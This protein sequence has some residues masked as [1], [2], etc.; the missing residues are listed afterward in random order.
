MVTMEEKHVDPRIQLDVD[1]MILDYLLFTTT[2][3]IL[4]HQEKLKENRDDARNNNTM[5]ML[6]QLVDCRSHE[7][8]TSSIIML[9]A[10]PAYLIMF[11]A[12]HPGLVGDEN[13]RLRLRLLKFTIMFTNRSG[14]KMTAPSA[15]T[16]KGLREKRRN[17][18]S[19]F[20][21]GDESLVRDILPDLTKYFAPSDASA[22]KEEQMSPNASPTLIDPATAHPRPSLPPVSL[23]DTL[24]AFMALSAAQTAV[25]GANITD[26][27]MHLAGGY[28]VQAVAEQYL[29]YGSRR[30]DV[31]QEAFA[32]GFDAD[33]DADEGSDEWQINAMFFGEDEVVNGWDGIRDK[34]M[35][36]VS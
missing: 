35:G 22:I 12:I 7:S 26:V 23:L 30:A 29:L 8:N 5:S 32:W 16:M 24:P 3:S 2:R 13:I 33:C 4:E 28:M 14:P 1:E 9:I 27:W 31:L 34:H 10:L 15:T 6:M 17:Q 36:A 21:S 11:H 20:R 19:S 18:A 25:Q